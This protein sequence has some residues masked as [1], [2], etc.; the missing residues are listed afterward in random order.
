[1]KRMRVVCV[2]LVAVVTIGP[3]AAAEEESGLMTAYSLDRYRP[4]LEK[5]P[6]AK[7]TAPE[8]AAGPLFGKDL[9]LTGH[10]R[11]GQIGYVLLLNR[12]TQE[13]TTVSS[14]ETKESGLRLISLSIESDPSKTQA[15]VQQ[16]AERA[17]LGFDW[18]KQPRS[19]DEENASE[20]RAKTPNPLIQ[21]VRPIV[22][23][24]PEYRQ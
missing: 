5:S 7:E 18:Q 17:T 8:T 16:G 1:M 24:A 6:F 13:R 11:L 23:E 3:G 20:A 14:A 2:V 15:V 19:A 12:K 22:P 9:A 4:M 21:R 10:Y